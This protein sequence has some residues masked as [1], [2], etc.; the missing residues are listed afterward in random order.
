M[1]ARVVKYVVKWKQDMFW[2]G[3]IESTTVEYTLLMAPI[4]IQLKK[5]R[6]GY[7]VGKERMISEIL[8]TGPI[9][10]GLPLFLMNYIRIK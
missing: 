3:F 10:V 7:S 4:I 5:L 8:V 6:D 9:L 1:K 2:S